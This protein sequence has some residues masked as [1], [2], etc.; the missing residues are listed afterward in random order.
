MMPETWEFGVYKEIECLRVKITV[1]EMRNTL[2][3]EKKK[4]LKDGWKEMGGR[5][6]WWEGENRF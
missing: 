4:N 3:G 1:C 5:I 6:R 2:D